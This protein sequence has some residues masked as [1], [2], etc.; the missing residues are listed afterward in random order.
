MAR[1][2]PSSEGPAAGQTVEI[3]TSQGA[4]RAHV[5]IP[6]RAPAVGN[7]VLGHGAGGGVQARDLVAVARAAAGAG[8]TA[9]LVEQPWRVAG[10]RVAAPPPRLDEAW[11]A[12][13]GHLLEA[14]GGVLPADVPLVV[15]GRSAGARVACRT[16]SAL[17][18]AGV[19]CLAFPLHPPSRSS[20]RPPSSR[21]HELPRDVPT[22]VVQGR[23]DPFGGPD[24]V[25]AAAP[26]PSVRVVGVDGD[27]GLSRATAEIVA[28]VVPWLAGLTVVE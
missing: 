24:D 7:L 26:T 6:D 16:G 19:L 25:E 1:T 8:W 18:A 12:V 13:L 15:G 3:G 10:R 14:P 2:P 17:A 27:H 9:V 5:R 21:A 23:R 11:L 22:L 28:A 4:A 20:T